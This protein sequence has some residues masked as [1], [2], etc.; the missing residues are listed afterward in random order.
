MKTPLI[1]GLLLSVAFLFLTGC[2]HLQNDSDP[3]LSVFP[4][5]EQGTEEKPSDDTS[6]PP[7][8]NIKEEENRSSLA[9]GEKDDS[10]S[11]QPEDSAVEAD[12]DPESMAV[13]VNKE[14]SLPENYEPDDLVYP[15]VPF[16]FDEMIDKRMM[17]KEA[18]EALEKLFAAA[19]EDGVTLLGVSAYRSYDTQEQLYNN[20]VKRDGEEAAQTYSAFPGHSEHQTGLAID[21][22]GGD[23][24]CVVE[25]CFAGTE[26]AKWLEENAA[27]FGFIIRYLEGK[28]LITGYKYEPWH[29]RYVGKEMA[30]A[31]TALGVT[32]EEYYNVVPVSN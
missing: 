15:D 20:Y 25:D 6:L 27:E 16:T 23:R 9:E 14:Y 18:G 17:R 30:E 7:A 26:E 21:V 22:T 13:I 32:L 8:D 10:N 1:T 24:I 5:T 2:N 19:A 12:T 11:T 29:I 3:D 31:I 4:Q 28:E